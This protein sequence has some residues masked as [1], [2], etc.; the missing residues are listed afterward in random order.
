MGGVVELAPGV[1]MGRAESVGAKFV[2]AQ[3][4]GRGK[5]VELGDIEVFAAHAVCFKGQ[6]VWI[7]V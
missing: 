5:L 7:G 1:A 4:D 6:V 3:V 2:V